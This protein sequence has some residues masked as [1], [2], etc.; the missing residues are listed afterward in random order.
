MGEICSD[1]NYDKEVVYIQV[2]QQKKLIQ[3]LKRR[4]LG[5]PRFIGDTFLKV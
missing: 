3:L 5:K 2:L 1:A 4:Q